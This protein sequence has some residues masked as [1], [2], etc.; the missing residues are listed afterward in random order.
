MKAKSKGQFKKRLA[1][2]M[3]AACLAITALPAAV[4]ADETQ[5]TAASGQTWDILAGQMP[6][7]QGMAQNA[8]YILEVSTGTNAGGAA[9]DNVMY[10]AVH[11]TDVNG[12]K[13]SEI[14]MPG[15]DA[16]ER[17]FTAA[18]TAGNRNR[19]IQTVKNLFG[20]TTP[21]LIE[22]KA[23]GSVQ[24]DQFLFTTPAKVQHFDKIQIFGKKTDADA[25]HSP[26]H[27]K[28]YRMEN[29]PEKQASN[30]PHKLSPA[31]SQKKK[32]EQEKPLLLPPD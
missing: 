2:A 11:Y 24:T 22:G 21:D 13:R 6:A 9:A 28:S 3:L 12:R 19:R 31:C 1:A 7:S 20:Y 23:M 25:I 17:G 29:P 10:F 27:H 5:T 8:T 4:F 18:R 32:L 30:Q 16:V 15:I 14:I 26:C